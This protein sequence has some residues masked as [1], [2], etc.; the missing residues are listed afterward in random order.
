MLPKPRRPNSFSE[1]GGWEWIYVL[2]TLDEQVGS[3]H[4]S[5]DIKVANLV[6][7]LDEGVLGLV[8]VPFMNHAPVLLSGQNELSSCC[9]HGDRDDGCCHC[10]CYCHSS[11]GSC[12]CPF[13]PLRH[14]ALWSSV[15]YPPT[16]S[17]GLL[18]QF[19]SCDSPEC[20]CTYPLRCRPNIL[21]YL[22]V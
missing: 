22:S 3:W 16:W 9:S 11:C 19:C 5:V 14:E 8:Y 10:P 21:Q 1:M 18:N 15:D 4:H 13:Y 17:A 2:Y 6:S 20:V 12:S 7:H